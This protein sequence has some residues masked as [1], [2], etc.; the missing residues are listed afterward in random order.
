MNQRLFVLCSEYPDPEGSVAGGFVHTRCLQYQR[1]GIEVSVF[2]YHGAPRDYCFDGISV[3]V[4]A[5][6]RIFEAINSEKPDACAVHFP[7]RQFCDG[8]R[9]YA[10][11]MPFG[12]WFHGVETLSWQRRLF[13]LNWGSGFFRYVLG[14]MRQLHAL[15]RFLRAFR[16]DER[17][18]LVYVSKWM[19]RIAQRD[20]H[21]HIPD[22]SIIPN[23]IDDEFFSYSPK[24][25]EDRFEILLIRSFSSRK[26][27]NDIA[28]DGIRK[29]AAG[30]PDLFGN[31]TF[32]IFGKGRYFK[33]LTGQLGSF[34]NVV[35]AERFFEPRLLPEIHRTAGVFLCPTRQDAQGVSMCE[36]MA[37]GLVPVT[38][39]NTAIPEFVMHGESGLLTESSDEIASA[40]ETLAANPA[41][42]ARLSR[43]AAGDIRS[44]C[45]AESV[46]SRELRVLGLGK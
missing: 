30:N 28:V 43:G 1:R 34:P 12:L 18:R 22:F 23:P 4:R 39:R 6:T 10:P 7:V 17:I 29:F 2:V 14:N 40:L 36:A 31:C 3:S 26:Y 20:L 46:T 41:L 11:S 8:F 35:C 19:H 33:P 21:L 13:D 27:A 37:S 5:M 42:F 16:G 9:A 45:A 32:R 25:A 24:R 38:S 15:R 44:L